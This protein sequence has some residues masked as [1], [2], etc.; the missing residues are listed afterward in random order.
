MH[1]EGGADASGNAEVGEMG[2]LDLLWKVVVGVVHRSRSAECLGQV[3]GDG[4]R[5]GGWGS[6]WAGFLMSDGMRFLVG[7]VVMIGYFE[8][9]NHSLIADDWETHDR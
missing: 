6:R 2:H 9:M 8:M 4:E 7:F 5:R 1:L 3:E